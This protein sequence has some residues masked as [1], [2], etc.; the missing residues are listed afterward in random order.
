M[1]HEISGYNG[2]K[3]VVHVNRL[4]LA[5]NEVVKTSNPRPRRQRREGTRRTSVSSESCEG[6]DAITL[7][8][9]P[10]ITNLPDRDD[11]S[12]PAYSLAL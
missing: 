8:R 9:L 12:R 7:G 11:S 5:Y 6:P 3:S 2:R 4:K 1:N 10:L